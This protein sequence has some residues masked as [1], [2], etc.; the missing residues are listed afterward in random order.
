MTGLQ[1]ATGATERVSREA[2]E[3]ALSE[4]GPPGHV[5]SAFSAVTQDYLGNETRLDA[6]QVNISTRPS[7]SLILGVFSAAVL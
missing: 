2:L 3:Q 1:P 5:R 7:N 6:D 4:L